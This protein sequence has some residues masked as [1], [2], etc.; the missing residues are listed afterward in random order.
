MRANLKALLL[1]AAVV[2]AGITTSR[3][4]EFRI[5][6]IEV[7]NSTYVNIHFDTVANRAYALQYCTSLTSTN[8]N[9]IP[10]GVWSN[11]FFT[12]AQPFQNHYVISD[13]RTN[14]QRY[15]RLRVTP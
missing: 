1:C 14:N 8:T 10:T 5:E 13:F 3:G 4:A 6:Y 12:P 11:L 9:G 7:L 15:Y 2:F